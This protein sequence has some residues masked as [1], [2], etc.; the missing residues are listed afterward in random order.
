MKLE[1]ELIG[2]TL[3]FDLCPWG[4]GKL[5]KGTKHRRGFKGARKGRSCGRASV[6]LRQVLWFKMEDICACL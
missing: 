6:G 4:K 3:D 5:V 2:H 1:G